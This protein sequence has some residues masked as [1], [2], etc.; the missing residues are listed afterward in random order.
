ML[1]TVDGTGDSAPVLAATFSLDSLIL[2]RLC[3]FVLSGGD[4][5]QVAPPSSFLVQELF[6]Q[7]NQEIEYSR[8]MH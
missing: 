8:V 7:L 1:S 4:F 3:V 6:F 2:F 5:D